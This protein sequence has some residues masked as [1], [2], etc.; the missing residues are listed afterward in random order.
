MAKGDHY[1]AVK[2]VKNGKDM[3]YTR[4][5]TSAYESGAILVVLA[6]KKGDKVWIQRYHGDRLLHRSYNLF[7]VYLIST[8]I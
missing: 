5:S 4:S 2:M 8:Q 1:I 3:A 6:L 7:S